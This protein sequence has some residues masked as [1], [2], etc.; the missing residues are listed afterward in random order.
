MINK[1]SGSRPTPTDD[2][3]AAQ[4]RRLYELIDTD[5]VTAMIALFAEDAVYHRPGYEPLVG[6][7]ALAHFYRHERVIREGRHTLHTVLATGTDVAVHGA[8]AGVL[9]DGRQARHRFAEFFT[10]APDGRIVRRDTFFFV[11]LV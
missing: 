5:D 1:A 2:Q 9:R 4:T 7:E 8:F 3:A 6:H 11:P 10:L